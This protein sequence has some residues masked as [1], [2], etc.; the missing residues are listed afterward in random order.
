[1]GRHWCDLNYY[2]HKLPS[3]AAHVTVSFQYA[4][5]WFLEHR[6]CR[7]Y[8]MEIVSSRDKVVGGQNVYI[9]LVQFHWT[10]YIRPL[11]LRTNH[12]PHAHR[13]FWY[14][15]F[16]M[17]FP[18]RKYH[19]QKH[20]YPC[21]SA[22]HYHFDSFRSVFCVLLDRFGIKLFWFGLKLFIFIVC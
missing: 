20:Y 15:V 11:M 1:M 21:Q 5:I 7:Q 13:L 12:Q 6:P 8:T 16:E 4:Q 14:W 22:H 9:P 10:K 3:C 19:P 17:G 2:F 18:E